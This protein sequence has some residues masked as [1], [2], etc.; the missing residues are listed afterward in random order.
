MTFLIVL[1]LKPKVCDK[2]ME[3]MVINAHVKYAHPTLTCGHLYWKLSL[4]S[5]HAINRLQ[6]LLL[7]VNASLL[8]DNQFDR[9]EPPY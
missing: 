3:M 8:F 2:M 1:H 9:E 4:K 5:I 7:A 6:Y